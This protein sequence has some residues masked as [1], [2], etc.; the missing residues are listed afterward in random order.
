MSEEK[1]EPTFEEALIELQA[2]VEK[3][4]S[5]DLTLEESLAIYERGQQLVAYCSQRLEN[6]SLK[7]EQLSAEGEIVELDA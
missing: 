6:A 4:E 1:N 7:V 3:L 5:G 2:T